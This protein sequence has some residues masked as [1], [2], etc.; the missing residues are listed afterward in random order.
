[1]TAPR[2]SPLDLMRA[3]ELLGPH[4]GGDS[5]RA[6]HTFVAAVHALPPPYPDSLAVFQ[7]CTGW[8]RWPTEPAREVLGLMGRRSGKTFV[9]AAL[10]I[11]RC[12][13]HEHQL[14]PGTEGV[15][16]CIAANQR[17]ASVLL[18]YVKGLLR[19][20]PVLASE[21][22]ADTARS[23]SF[24]N[25]TRL[26]VHAANFRGIRGLTV[27]GACVDELAFLRSS[28]DYSAVPAEELLEA[29]RPA[30]ATVPD[31]VL[32]LLSSPYGKRSEAYRLFDRYF[33][34]EDAPVLVWRAATRTMNPT[35]SERTVRMAME[36]DEASARAEYLAEFRSDLEAFVSR[37][38]VDACTDKG[39]TV[40]PFDPRHRYVA[41]VDPSG[42]RVDA[43]TLGIAHSEARDGATVQVLDCLVAVEPP[44][45]PDATVQ[46]F[47]EVA[48][49]YRITSVT[50]DRYAAE[51]AR[52]P[53]SR[54][55]IR[56]VQSDQTR[57]DLYLALLPLLTSARVRLLDLP[58][59][60]LQLTGLERRTSTTGRDRIDHAPGGHDDAANAAAG[61]LVSL[62]SKPAPFLAA[63]V[64]SEAFA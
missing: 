46:R 54:R 24:R 9:T 16:M 25:G 4:L 14:P 47:V 23:I 58:A 29:L 6:W 26:E 7:Q 27:I 34:K 42:G 10:A 48:R 37:E 18:R 5:F 51:W 30:M 15:F 57:S 22:V 60:G 59:L 39:I 52:Q 43:M 62:E 63:A 11:H 38:V 2:L 55:G 17:Q 64:W 19:A 36:R 21:I 41:F 33:G 50:G 12:L 1:V 44:F 13:F 20:V 61:A 35:V 28:A 49:E 3:P 40:R 53:F 45:N 31:A 32:L 56:Y 8:T